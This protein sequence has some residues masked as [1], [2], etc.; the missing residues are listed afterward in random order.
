MSI[1]RIASDSG[2]GTSASLRQLFHRALGVSPQ[3]YR[4]T[5]RGAEV[6]PNGAPRSPGTAA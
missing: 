5:F 3:A 4:N 1:E 6:T 2:F